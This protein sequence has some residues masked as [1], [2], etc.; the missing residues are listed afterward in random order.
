M[1]N[2]WHIMNYNH[3]FAV[4]KSKFERILTV[5]IMPTMASLTVTDTTRCGQSSKPQ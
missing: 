2:Y 1:N 4:S 5:L 3:R